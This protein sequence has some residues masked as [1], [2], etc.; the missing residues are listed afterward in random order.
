MKYKTY[1]TRRRAKFSSIFEGPVNLPWGTEV[2][3]REVDGEQYI[4]HGD[5]LLCAAD[6]QITKNFFVQSDDGRGI[7][8]GKL[9][10]AIEKQLTPKNKRDKSSESRWSKIWEDARCKPYKRPDHEDFWLWNEDFYNA[11]IEDLEHIA[12]LTGTKI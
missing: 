4:F 12:G 8:R 7:E 9:I 2:E 6:S 3:G 5:R 1:V 11:P 10:T